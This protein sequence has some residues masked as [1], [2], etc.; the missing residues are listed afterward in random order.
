MFRHVDSPRC[1]KGEEP[2]DAPPPLPV[3]TTE[4]ASVS[5]EQL[6]TDQRKKRNGFL[7]TTYAGETGST[8]LGGKSFLG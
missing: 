7:T 5:A 1:Y 4:D 6:M 8:G 2:K 3:P